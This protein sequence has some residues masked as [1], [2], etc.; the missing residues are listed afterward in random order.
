MFHQISNKE[1]S[2][3]FEIT[4]KILELLGENE[5]K[6][7][8]YSIAAFKINKYPI[9]L[10]SLTENEIANEE[11]F[12]KNLRPKIIE[13][14]NTGNFSYLEELIQQVPD[15]L[16]DLLQ[17]KGLGAKKIKLLHEELGIQSIGELLYACQEN[18][19]QL[20]KGFGKKTQDQI[21]KNIQF[22]QSSSNKYLYAEVSLFC[23]ALSEKIKTSYPEAQFI[24]AG[25]YIRQQP[26]IN[27]IDIFT[28][29]STNE[30]IELIK[31][32]TEEENIQIDLENNCIKL[33]HLPIII[34]HA[35]NNDSGIKM[36]QLNASKEFFEENY[37][38]L[39]NIIGFIDHDILE[40][41][42]LPFTHPAQREIFNSQPKS[43]LEQF[44]IKGLIHCHST[45]SDGSHSI[46]E[47]AKGAIKKGM[48][49]MVITDHSVAAFYANGLTPERIIQQHEEI[50]LLNKKLA[51]FKIFKGIEADILYNGQL[52]YNEDIWQTFDVII[53]SVHTQLKMTKEK[54]TERVL[55]A[56][57]NP[58]LTML[59]HPTGRLLLS[60]EG[61]DLDYVAIFQK[62]SEKKI[63]IE[64]NAHPRRLD[65][66]Y[67]LINKALDK[68]IKI[69]I[70]SDAHSVEGIDVLNFGILT[71]QKTALTMNNNI[72]SLSLEQ[73]EAY[74]K[75]RTQ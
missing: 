62:C 39:H 5:F 64:L 67:T 51:P 59:G 63:A 68:G 53:G 2:K 16:I 29:L 48:E 37:I 65:L 50:E 35:L 36:L 44:P 9:P 38:N 57:D 19:I 13:I 3:L 55:T 1:L 33:A 41:N 11:G 60:R 21:I 31:E 15:G 18:R 69:S 23:K 40:S 43:S 10:Y 34:L 30:F 72:S 66:D 17:I 6:I 26:I 8:S 47:M 52:D 73:F 22:I 32:N 46:E 20:L 28:T 70:N 61:Y 75:N 71:A 49:Y 14:L 58:F 7:K 54:A 4:S 12:N 42:N 45:W 27:S 25:E 74:L 24:Y 56:L